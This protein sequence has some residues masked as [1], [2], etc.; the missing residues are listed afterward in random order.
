[1]NVTVSRLLPR[2][3]RFVVAV[4]N[5]GSVAQQGGADRGEIEAYQALLAMQ[6]G[7]EG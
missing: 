5:H 3:R 1:M 6:A 7:R 4:M 2:A